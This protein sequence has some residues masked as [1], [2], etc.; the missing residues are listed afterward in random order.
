MGGYALN[1]RNFFV[2]TVYITMLMFF[3]SE[4]G[5]FL[6]NWL[7]FNQY[8]RGLTSSAHN[9]CR[10]YCW[11]RVHVWLLLSWGP[12]DIWAP[13]YWLWPRMVCYMVL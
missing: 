12:W 8:S 4:V 6:I 1:V 11:A 10:Y 9:H 2:Y 7:I 13:G 5:F 3:V